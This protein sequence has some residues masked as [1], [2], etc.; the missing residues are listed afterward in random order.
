MILHKVR[1]LPGSQ[2]SPVWL[3]RNEVCFAMVKPLV[4]FSRPGVWSIGRVSR[5][6]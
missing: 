1:D 4:V 6:P 3:G 2:V 5:G